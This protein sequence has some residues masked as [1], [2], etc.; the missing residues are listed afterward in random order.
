M[1]WRNVL[2]DALWTQ[3]A[4]TAD[5]HAALAGRSLTNWY[6]GSGTWQATTYGD[7]VTARGSDPWNTMGITA[8]QII[9]LRGCTG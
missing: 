2:D 5:V 7:A 3:G 8:G 9:E 1:S 4:I 6:G